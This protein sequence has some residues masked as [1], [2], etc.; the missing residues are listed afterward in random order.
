[1]PARRGAP[2][3]DLHNLVGEPLV[4]LLRDADVVA[5]DV[6]L[7]VSVEAGADEDEV[8]PEAHHRRQDLR[9][10]SGFKV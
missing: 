8:R 6:V 10:G 5:V 9:A 1:M 2:V 3:G 4:L 7:L